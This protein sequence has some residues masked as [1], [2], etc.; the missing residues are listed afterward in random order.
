MIMNDN[1]LYKNRVTGRNPPPICVR[2]PRLGFIRLCASFYDLYFVGRN[3]HVCLEMGLFYRENE[4]FNRS[5]DCM[6]LG[7]KGVKIVKPEDGGGLFHKPGT[8]AEIDAGFDDIEEYDE[9][10]VVRRR[11]QPK[12]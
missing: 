1:V 8:D 4:V 6:R 2:M 3:M 5:F 11:R 12:N 10:A 7:D 9:N